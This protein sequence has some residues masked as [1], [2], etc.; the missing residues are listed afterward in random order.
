[1][2]RNTLTVAGL[3]M[4]FTGVCLGAN[5]QVIDLGEVSTLFG[6]PWPHLSINDQGQVAGTEP[7][8]LPFNA[9]VWQEGVKSYIPP[10]AGNIILAD[11]I[12][13]SGLA[14]GSESDGFMATAFYWQNNE[15]KYL[16]MDNSY[17]Q[18]LAVNDSNVIVGYLAPDPM[19]T[20]LTDAVI[21]PDA[22]NIVPVEKLYP[23][24]TFNEATDINNNN[25]VV[26]F[27]GDDTS[28]KAFLWQ[29]GLPPVDLDP[30]FAYTQMAA[31][32]IN[33]DDQV[34]GYL[35]GQDGKE[36]AF[37]WQT[38]M[39][40]PLG[41]I[42]D[43]SWAN[44]INDT[45]QVVGT[46]SITPDETY[47]C[48]W[49]NGMPDDLNTLLPPGENW[50]L[51]E[52]HDINNSGWIVGVGVN[53]DGL[54]NH[55]FL[56]K[57]IVVANTAPLA[58][59]GEDQTLYAPAGEVVEVTLDGLGSSDADGDPLEYFWSWTIEDDEFTAT[60]VTP[61]IELPLGVHVIELIVND[62]QLDSEPDYVTI[63]VLPE[64]TTTVEEILEEAIEV[65]NDLDT[66]TLKNKN[67]ATPL[68]NKIEA[69]LK[70]IDNGDYFEALN[71]LENDLL[72]K[73]DGCVKK[74]VPDKN[75]WITTCP[76]Q[77]QLY[78]LIMDAIAML[79][80]LI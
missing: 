69:V 15:K 57:T 13:N 77:E 79:R 61:S 30:S 32:A 7:D 20:W 14:I 25:K 42:G 52:A 17:G 51:T 37:I 49:Q 27:S 71:K 5:Y 38:D 19:A 6:E 58:D 8:G 60:G 74:G 76:E 21:W 78:S 23:A 12:N 64:P 39:I 33:N 63:E 54:Q 53:P 11:D 48:I 55:G 70:Q 73:T 80:E 3:V 31:S 45:E 50:I 43:Q 68:T 67:S 59:A 36:R 46:Y 34:V 2:R 22:N 28:K 40:T 18:A 66:S 1:M 72:G 65:I 44:A 9:Y 41:I 75:D 29:E 62:G 24:D 26:G 10:D 47:A 16:E 56:L 4:F 35:V